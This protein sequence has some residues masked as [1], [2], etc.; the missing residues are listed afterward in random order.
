MAAVGSDT[1]GLDTPGSDI[2]GLVDNTSAV[3]VVQDIVVVVVAGLKRPQLQQLRAVLRQHHHEL[4]RE[5]KLPRHNNS[6]T[7]QLQ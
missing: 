4:Y 7:R 3:P 2:V 5:S 1:L 6:K